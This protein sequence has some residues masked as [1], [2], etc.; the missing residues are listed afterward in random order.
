MNIKER[1]F[2][3]RLKQKYQLTIA[4]AA[5]A[6]AAIGLKFFLF[7]SQSRKIGCDSNNDCKDT[8]VIVLHGLVRSAA[9]MNK[10]AEALNQNGYTV[11]NLQY[12]SRQ[13]TISKLAINSVYPEIQKCLPDAQERSLNFV[14]H[15]MGGI[16]VRQ[17]ASSTDLKLNRV[18]MLSPPNQGSELVDKL[19]VI[20]FFKFINGEAGLSLGTSADSVPNSL[21]RVDFTTGIITGDRSLN[22]FYSYLIPGADDGKVAVASAKVSGM[23]D[24]LVVPHSHSFIMNSPV[25]IEQTIYF[26][27]HGKF[28][29]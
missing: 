5:I 21:G 14:T 13:G 29:H 24:F 16:I 7:P 3:S 9:A 19:K 8:P 23:Q 1:N 12:P 20:P 2:N 26:L 28:N 6:I 22:P 18:V 11:C 27:D 15:S 25:A 4:T 17:L 10:I